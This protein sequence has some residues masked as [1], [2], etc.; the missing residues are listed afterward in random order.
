MSY[1]KNIFISIHQK[2]IIYD[3]FKQNLINE[4]FKQ[5]T[6]VVLCTSEGTFETQVYIMEVVK[7]AKHR[8]IKRR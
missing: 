8:R 7:P 3:L 6:K 2:T 1:F 5:K 4:N